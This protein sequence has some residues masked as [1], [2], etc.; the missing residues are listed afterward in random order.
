MKFLSFSP[1]LMTNRSQSHFGF[2]F[3][4]KAEQFFSLTQF[5][6]LEN[7]FS[8]WIGA[9][10]INTITYAILQ[11][12]TKNGKIRKYFHTSSCLKS[13]DD[14]DYPYE[15]IKWSTKTKALTLIC[16]RLAVNL[17]YEFVVNKL[18]SWILNSS[19]R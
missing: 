6:Q 9:G 17:N 16:Q 18:S 10:K 4:S 15:S 1:T 2:S 13:W 8:S 14:F 3:S 19:G 7:T 11:S 12:D 5:Y